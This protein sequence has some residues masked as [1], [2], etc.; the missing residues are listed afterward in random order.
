[1][2]WLHFAYV[3]NYMLEML[4]MTFLMVFVTE[5]GL[6]LFAFGGTFFRQT[7]YVLDLSMVMA[8]LMADM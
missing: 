4:N 6:L 1:M 5:L 3:L 2:Q 8:S 7:I